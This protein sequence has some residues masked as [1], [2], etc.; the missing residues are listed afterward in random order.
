MASDNAQE[1]QALGELIRG[2]ERRVNTITEYMSQA[3][4]L[5]AELGR[6]QDAMASELRSALAERRSLRRKDFDRLL[7]HVVCERRERLAALPA[8]IEQFRGAEHAV[9]AKLRRLL[10]G[11]AAGVVQAWPELRNEMVS[12]QRARE[13]QVARAL[14]RVHVEQEE[15]CRGLRG[16]LARGERVR[17]ADLK[18]VVREI[19]AVSPHELVDLTAVLQDCRS[20][21]AEV[22]EAWQEVV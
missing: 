7:G 22:L 5:L 3:A 13:R 18:A 10:E 16:L 9:V 15:L 19:H 6:E 17:I 12:L 14:R 21:C 2:Y 1:V 4:D 11:T 20:A 8:L